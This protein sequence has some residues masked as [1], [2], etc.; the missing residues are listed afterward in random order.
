LEEKYV[1]S[2]HQA[3]FERIR[4]HDVEAYETNLK[5]KLERMHR[6]HARER[7]L[8]QQID[9]V[10]KQYGGDLRALH[11]IHQKEEKE[12]GPFVREIRAPLANR[13]VPARFDDHTLTTYSDSVERLEAGRAEFVGAYSLAPRKEDF[14]DVP[15]E[16][17]NPWLFPSTPQVIKIGS[18]DLGSGSGCWGGWVWAPCP[19]YTSV[20]GFVPDKPGIIRVEPLIFAHGFYIVKSDDTCVSCKSAQVYASIGMS[21]TQQQI[22][23]R[24]SNAVLVD[25]GS[26]NIYDEGTIDQLVSVQCDRVVAE[27]EPVL[28]KVDVTCA[29]LARGGGSYAEVNFKTGENR[30]VCPLVWWHPIGGLWA[31]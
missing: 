5:L 14:E 24:S 19:I 7:H 28:I 29:A 10:V 26:D 23:T 9:A 25:S 2:I 12:L 1:M 4:K 3:E 8:G 11:A 18:K 13:H 27:N 17:G 6:R 30:I 22:E 21:V 20:F 31:Y 15:G 16:S